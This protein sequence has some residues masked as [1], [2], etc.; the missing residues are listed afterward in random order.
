MATSTEFTYADPRLPTLVMLPLHAIVFLNDKPYVRKKT[1]SEVELEASI[2]A[3]H[4]TLSVCLGRHTYDQV[5]ASH[6]KVSVQ[7][8]VP[9]GIST[10][11]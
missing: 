8:V 7:A 5:Q 6:A 4:P 9:P 10:F 1:S 2:G 3:W 11:G